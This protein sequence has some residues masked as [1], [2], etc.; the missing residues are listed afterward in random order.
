M[1]YIPS[2]FCFVET[3][4]HVA[5]TTLELEME[6][7]LMRQGKNIGKNYE[8]TERQSLT[9]LTPAEKQEVTD[10]DNSKT[11]MNQD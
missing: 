5:Q 6:P 10:T 4:F 3:E 7:G 11:A 8:D 1:N 2:L 9:P